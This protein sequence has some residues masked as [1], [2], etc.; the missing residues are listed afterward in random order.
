MNLDIYAKSQDLPDDPLATFSRFLVALEDGSVF[1]LEA[2]QR[3]GKP[4]L[5][6]TGYSFPNHLIIEPRVGNVVTLTND[7]QAEVV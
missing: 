5:E 3:Y 4:A 1:K 6:V 2:V 7:P